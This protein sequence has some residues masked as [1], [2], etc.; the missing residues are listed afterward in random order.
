MNVTYKYIVEFIIQ[1]NNSSEYIYNE[2]I[3]LEDINSFEDAI[4]WVYKNWEK[5][6]NLNSYSD[7]YNFVVIVKENEFHDGK[8]HDETNREIIIDEY[9]MG[10]D[11]ELKLYNLQKY[12]GGKYTTVADPRCSDEEDCEYVTIRLAD[13]TLNPKRYNETD[14]FFIV[15]NYDD[16]T[17]KQWGHYVYQYDITE[18]KYEDAIDFI[19]SKVIEF[20]KKQKLKNLIKETIKEVYNVN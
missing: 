19:K 18:M 16:P 10:E 7:S 4:K 12:F 13:H 15:K 5:Y 9:G 2:N 1:H 14:L 11:Y 3:E 8:I 20:L 6:L 17:E